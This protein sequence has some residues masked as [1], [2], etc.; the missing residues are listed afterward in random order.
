MGTWIL[1]SLWCI[2]QVALISAIGVAISR[3]MSRRYPRVGAQVTAAA[4]ITI[5]AITVLLPITLPSVLL[6]RTALE[7][8]VGQ[9]DTDAGAAA[10]DQSNG[11]PSASQPEPILLDAQRLLSTALSFTTTSVASSQTGSWVLV[12]VATIATGFVAWGMLGFLGA[13]RHI[14]TL[15]R[16]SMPIEDPD[17]NRRLRQLGEKLAVK[18]PVAL[19]ESK[20]VASATVIGWR[21]PVILLPL[22]WQSWTSDQF[23]AALAHELAHVRRKDFL[24]RLLSSFARAL[25]FYH[26]LMHRL[27]R[28]L[29][30]S[31]ELAAD[32]LAASATGDPTKYLKALSQL[33]I[34][35]DDLTRLRAEPIVLPALSTDLIRRIKM[36][37]AK[38]CNHNSRAPLGLHALAIGAVVAVGAVTMVLR[39]SAEPLNSDVNTEQSGRTSQVTLSETFGDGALFNRE[40]LDI[41]L[42]GD[43]ETG[44]FAL[45][46]GELTRHPEFRPVMMAMNKLLGKVMQFD[47]GANPEPEFHLELIDHVIGSVAFTI[48]PF[49]NPAGDE[50]K[51]VVILG[52]SELAIRFHYDV[53][54]QDWVRQN[55]PGAVEKSEGDLVYFEY[56]QPA[57]GP[58]PLL[59]AALDGRTIIMALSLEQLQKM[60]DQ[61]AQHRTSPALATEWKATD[62]GFCTFVVTDKTIEPIAPSPD[63]PGE[64]VGAEVIK[65]TR[66]FSLGLDVQE[67]T[68]EVGLKLSLVCEDQQSAESVQTAINTLIPMAIAKREKDA[69]AINPA[70]KF[71]N[72]YERFLIKLFAGCSTRV[73]ERD[74]KTF[75]VEIT[76]LEVFPLREM[77]SALAAKP[78]QS[79]AK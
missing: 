58:K 29:I 26:P 71:K 23:Q 65:H 63:K 32:R 9:V 45:R 42:V 5:L 77:V 15:R 8:P 74:D 22:D 56:L 12:G 1:P 20:E 69:A 31:Q 50:H 17:A 30:L 38:D 60:A 28:Q 14:L 35:Q 55:V 46:L 48:K 21:Q 72:A 49:E 64:L 19:R 59:V 16:Q 3:S 75:A 57:F 13:L 73:V 51:N 54:W 53:P 24:W 6:P 67:Q 40:P 33:A 39:S 7:A 68:G 37:R 79:T 11:A 62:G 52:S 2:M 36:L 43:N 76:G 78:G 66:M 34:G 25:H 4:T 70:S 47:A 27:V 10:A 18:T 44:A 61:S 41:S